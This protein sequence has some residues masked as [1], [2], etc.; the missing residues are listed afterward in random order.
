MSGYRR[1]MH[2]SQ[3]TVVNGT[4]Q[5]IVR[6]CF[7]CRRRHVSPVA[8]EPCV[9]ALYERIESAERAAANEKPPVAL[10]GAGG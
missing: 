4:R 5:V 6:W 3:R 1:W 8:A 10:A 7:V 9:A 2:D